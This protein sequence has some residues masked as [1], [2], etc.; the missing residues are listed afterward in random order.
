MSARFSACDYRLRFGVGLGVVQCSDL[1]FGHIVTF[2]CRGS[3]RCP[4][5]R[6]CNP[7]TRTVCA[8][9]MNRWYYR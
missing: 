9:I 5:R 2:G 7:K 4:H 3:H 8:D 1:H 6:H